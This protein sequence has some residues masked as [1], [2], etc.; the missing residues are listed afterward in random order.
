MTQG[1]E[2]HELAARANH[3]LAELEQELD[4]PE[5]AI[6]HMEKVFLGSFCR[7]GGDPEF[8][9]KCSTSSSSGSSTRWTPRWRWTR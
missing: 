1:G 5:K 6:D 8:G 3:F 9:W 4:H 7:K 2:K